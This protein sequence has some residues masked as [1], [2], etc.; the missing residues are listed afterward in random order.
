MHGYGFKLVKPKGWDHPQNMRPTKEQRP[1]LA[2][3]FGS[4]SHSWALCAI[5]KH[6]DLYMNLSMCR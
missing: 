5:V 6:K 3:H 2:P 1:S 4:V